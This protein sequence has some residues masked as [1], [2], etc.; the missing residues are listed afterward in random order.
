MCLLFFFNVRSNSCITLQYDMRREHHVINNN[1]MPMKKKDVQ[2]WDGIKIQ[3]KWYGVS[4]LNRKKYWSL[5][6]NVKNEFVVLFLGWGG[7]ILR[8][9]AI[10]SPQ[11]F[12]TL[13]ISIVTY[14]YRNNLFAYN[15]CFCQCDCPRLYHNYRL[16]T[17]Y[18]LQGKWK[19][20]TLNISMYNWWHFTMN[21]LV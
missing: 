15:I 8:L 6:K 21:A 11:V 20:L 2:Q 18:I 12:A 9:A 19:Y 7:G 13:F 16:P 4:L 14:K 5:F 3:V 1:A 17:T 10:Q